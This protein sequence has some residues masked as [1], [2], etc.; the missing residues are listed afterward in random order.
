ME[1]GMVVADVIAWPIFRRFGGGWRHHAVSAVLA[2]AALAGGIFS[3]SLFDQ[4]RATTPGGDSHAEASLEQALAFEICGKYG[5]IGDHTRQQKIYAAVD[6][7]R[8]YESMLSDE[9]GSIENY[10]NSVTT[11]IL[12]N[13]NSIFLLDSL[14][15]AV[16]AS[17][18]PIFLGDMHILFRCLI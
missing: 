5:F 6:K 3:N 13:E 17:A 2:V 16:N 4:A 11:R 15:I 9:Y 1:L 8:L 10:C 7:S 14:I 12:N 18:S